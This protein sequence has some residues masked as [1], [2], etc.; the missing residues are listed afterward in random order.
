MQLFLKR[1]KIFMLGNQRVTVARG[2][3]REVADWVSNSEDY[4]RGVSDG[5]IVD[6]TPPPGSPSAAV[7]AKKSTNEDAKAPGLTPKSIG[8]GEESTDT[9]KSRKR[10]R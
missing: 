8:L 5:S 10:D 7:Q 6:L 1:S 3:P 2:G 4:K 9:Q